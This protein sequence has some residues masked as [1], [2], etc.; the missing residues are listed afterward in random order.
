[1]YLAL[2]SAPAATKGSSDGTSISGVI[3][4]NS[5]S[6]TP[7]PVADIAALAARIAGLSSISA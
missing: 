5:I 1:M 6:S 2:S 3:L 7:T 4:T